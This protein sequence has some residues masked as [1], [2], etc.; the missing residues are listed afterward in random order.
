MTENL[1]PQS[2]ETL[3]ILDITQKTIIGCT[4]LKRR[5][6]VNR[7][8]LAPRQI[9]G[10]LKEFRFGRKVNHSFLIPIGI[11]IH[12][13]QWRNSH[14]LHPNKTSQNTTPLFRQCSPS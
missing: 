13:L 14:W 2:D 4:S 9:V 3:P 5:M 11:P 8:V 10:C 1:W 12:G 6:I 7:I